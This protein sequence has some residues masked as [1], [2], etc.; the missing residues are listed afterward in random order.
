VMV[1]GPS[2]P[3]L[4]AASGATLAGR[5]SYGRKGFFRDLRGNG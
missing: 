3:T 2:W 4:S 1:I 5:N